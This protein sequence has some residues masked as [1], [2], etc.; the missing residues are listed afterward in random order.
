MSDGA[1][2]WQGESDRLH[3]EI[4]RSISRGG[5]D[6]VTFEALALEIARFQERSIPGYARLL[7]AHGCRLETLEEL[8][9]VPVDAFRLTRVATY[10]SELDEVRFQTSGTT[11]A[12][13]GLHCMRR[14]DTYRLA[15][16]HW[17]K[18]ALMPQRLSAARVLCLMPPPKAP[19][20]SSLGFMMQAMGEEFDPG[21]DEGPSRWLMDE[22]S[23][24]DLDA[25]AA[26]L[27]DD[28]GREVLLLAT[29]FALVYLLDQLQTRR[30][31]QGRGVVVMQT[32]G[33]KGRCREL[34][35]EEL[36][37]RVG[38]VFGIEDA[39]V[40]GEYGMTELSSQ[41]Y[42]GIL[43]EGLL[44]GKKGRFLPPPW[45][46]I[47]AVDPVS[48]AVVPP[49]EV[50]LARFIDLA[51]VDSAVCLLTQDRIRSHPEG[52]ELLGRNPG[53]PPRGCSLLIEEL[54]EASR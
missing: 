53:A 51:N 42:E 43:P 28:A 10:P 50:G 39:C 44:S 1:A 31:P 17:G 49:G 4:Q 30:L 8:V 29:S 2:A 13:A 6:R 5:P 26:A 34:E 46:Q 54:L 40:V 36:R 16:L 7:R 9:P 48:L 37:R 23:R 27:R 21:S 24:I 3:Q 41:L 25:L 20:A 12:Q 18:R 11:G 14:T 15:A 45:L 52:V 33:T 35:G 47:D 32:G 22:S 38:E 19:P